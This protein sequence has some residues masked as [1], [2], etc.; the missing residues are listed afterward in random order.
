[1]EEN[2]TNIQPDLQE[3]VWQAE[4]QSSNPVGNGADGIPVTDPYVQRP[5]FTPQQ[6]FTSQPAWQP[7]SQQSAY[8]QT[9][10]QP[11]PDPQPTYQ[12]TYQQTAYQQTYQ[13]PQP[14]YQDP[15]VYQQYTTYNNQTGWKPVTQEGIGLSIS[16]MICGILSVLTMLVPVMGLL[17][18]ITGIVLAIVA[19]K[20]T[21]RMS[22]MAIT[23]LIC[24][25]VGLAFNVL[26]YGISIAI[27][28]IAS[29]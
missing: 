20:Q 5:N 12:Q 23:G 14:E 26:I 21:G 4:N 22:G 10:Q 28:I 29:M 6:N 2:M 1:M 24:G 25:I 16:S 27:A 8:Q 11:Q 9:Y 7:D 18:G 19:K 15:N 13:Q 17:L 3:A